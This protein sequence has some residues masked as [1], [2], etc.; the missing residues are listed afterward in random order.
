LAEADFMRVQEGIA[1]DWSADNFTFSQRWGI[2]I[3]MVLIEK[4]GKIIHPRM[5]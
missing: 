3:P 2:F 5:Q 1:A 4:V